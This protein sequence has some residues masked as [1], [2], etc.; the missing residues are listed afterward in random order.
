MLHRKVIHE[1]VADC[2]AD[3]SQTI[4]IDTVLE[5]KPMVGFGVGSLLFEFSYRGMHCAVREHE[6]MTMT[7]QTE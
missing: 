5:C 2:G 1:L 7:A 6:L 4:P 3:G